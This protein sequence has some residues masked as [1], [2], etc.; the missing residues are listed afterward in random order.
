MIGF[1]SQIRIPAF[2]KNGKVKTFPKCNASMKLIADRLLL[3]RAC[4]LLG[5]TSVK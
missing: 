4:F 3:S 1:L 2:I 5:F